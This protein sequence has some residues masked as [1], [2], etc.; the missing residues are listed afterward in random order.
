MIW[1]EKIYEIKSKP[2]RAG[3][4]KVVDCEN[5]YWTRFDIHEM[6]KYVRVYDSRFVAKHWLKISQ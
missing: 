1:N 3:K 2:N 5:N 4:F 6:E